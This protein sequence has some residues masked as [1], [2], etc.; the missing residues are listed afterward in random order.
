MKD[1]YKTVYSGADGQ[2]HI[3]CGWYNMP[4]FPT[5]RDS[6]AAQELVHNLNRIYSAGYQQAQED[7]REALG[8]KA[9]ET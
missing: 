8:I 6:L 1:F 9:I 5:T 4:G 3:T 7:I 2:W